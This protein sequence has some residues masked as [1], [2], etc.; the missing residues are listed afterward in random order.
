[1]GKQTPTPKS[2]ASA[3][4]EAPPLWEFVS[5]SAFVAPKSGAEHIV[6]RWDAVKR[7][8]KRDSAEEESPFKPESELQRLP[9]EFLQLLTGPVDW[10]GALS[11]LEE[12]LGGWSGAA[13]EPK[14]VFVVGAPW[15][16]H[17][18]ILRAW[19]AA[20]QA[21]CFEA[22]SYV[23]ILQYKRTWEQ[24]PQPGEQPWV[25]PE[26]ERCYVRHAEGLNLV[27]HFLE[28]ALRGTYG[29]GIIGCD[30]W[31]W[32]YLQHVWPAQFSSVLTLQAFDGARL[33]RLL[34]Q[35]S[36]T[37]IRTPYTFKNASSGDTV[38]CAEDGSDAQVS[39]AMVKL[40]VR[41]RGNVGLALRY[42]RDVLRSEPESAETKEGGAD[43]GESKE[44][45]APTVWVAPLPASPLP[46]ADGTDSVALILHTLLLHRGLPEELLP[47]L[48]PMSH[49]RIM[50]TLL[51]LQGRGIVEECEQ[52]WYVAPLGYAGTC[53]YLRERNYL[54]DQFWG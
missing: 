47:Q 34:R 14:V 32:A 52:F 21:S 49:A 12:A 40:A 16:G 10:S 46:P 22:P 1:M 38:L 51:R 35:L 28:Q 9:A 53:T 23:E 42:W 24:I 33:T 29:A 20:R 6:R 3:E 39:A 50:A 36:V 54:I 25:L 2:A 4:G 5:P 44:D 45:A 7:I 17:A 18:K 8:F 48:L 11:A 41:T 30:S 37:H 19:A 13:G 15:S 43:V 31:A 27:R 26:L